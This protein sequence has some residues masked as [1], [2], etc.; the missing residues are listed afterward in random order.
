MAKSILLALILLLTTAS[1]ESS[2]N[3]SISVYVTI[4]GFKNE[5]G[6]CR[7]LLFESEKGFPDSHEYAVLMLN[8]NIQGKTVKFSFKIKSG[9]YAISILH[10]ANSDGEMDKTWYGKPKEGFGVS[11]NPE[12]GFSSPDF[13]ESAVNLD[14]NNNYL[15]IRLNYL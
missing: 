4:E 2:A 1:G 9:K 8:E 14:G 13:E 10:D 11:N 6:I 7:L 5:E 15:V 12:V 3:D